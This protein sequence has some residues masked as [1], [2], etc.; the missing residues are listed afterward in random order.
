[1]IRKVLV[2]ILTLEFFLGGCLH[3]F[4]TEACGVQNIYELSPYCLKC[5]VTAA[6]EGDSDAMYVLS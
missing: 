1:M 2:A 4:G 5:K 6:K 3:Y